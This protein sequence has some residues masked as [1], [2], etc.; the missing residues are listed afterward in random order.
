MIT[1]IVVKLLELTGSVRTWS[2]PEWGAGRGMLSWRH[3]LILYFMPK[4]K[5]FLP[6]AQHTIVFR[7]WVIICLLV[8]E[9][10]EILS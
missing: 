2:T 8:D 10:F 9:P 6:P 3:L 5:R 7:R 1:I 4:F